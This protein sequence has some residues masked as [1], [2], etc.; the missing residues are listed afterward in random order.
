MSPRRAKKEGVLFNKFFTYEWWAKVLLSTTEKSQVYLD[1]DVAVCKAHS[2]AHATS[3]ASA[4]LT[5]GQP[6]HRAV[7]L[8]RQDC[9]KIISITPI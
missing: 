8:L 2:L 3:R 7:V 5:H 6:L 1:F 9:R 4:A